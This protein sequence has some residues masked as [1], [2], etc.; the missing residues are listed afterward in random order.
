MKLGK[1]AYM[2]RSGK[3]VVPK[4]AKNQ[5]VDAHGR[6]VY[7]QG[8]NLEYLQYTAPDNKLLIGISAG[9]SMSTVGQMVGQIVVVIFAGGTTKMLVDYSEVKGD[10]TV[11]MRGNIIK[12]GAA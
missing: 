11:W 9:T 2:L 4:A 12:E 8:R 3:P 7:R 1:Y 6:K 10:G 5:E